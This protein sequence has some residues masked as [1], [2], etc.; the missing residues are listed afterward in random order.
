MFTGPYRTGIGPVDAAP[1]GWPPL[2]S[3]PR[4]WGKVAQPI[5][6][7]PNTE[8]EPR[9]YI[10]EVRMGNILDTDQAYNAAQVKVYLFVTFHGCLEQK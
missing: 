2:G 6:F 1:A 3:R 10:N 7:D 4:R 8:L 5:R 9:I